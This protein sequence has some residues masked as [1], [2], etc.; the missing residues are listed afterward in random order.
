MS[1]GHHEELPFWRKYIFSTDHKMIGIQYSVTGLAFLFFGFC[2]MMLM[3]W[4]LAYPS[5]PI[6]LIGGLLGD[7]RA[8]GGIMLPDFYNELGAMHG[9]IMVFLGVVPL[10]VGGFGN[11]VLPLQLGA[12]DMA[13]PKI[14]M[15]SYW[16]LFLGG[17][18]MLGSFFLE[19]GAAQSGWTSYAPLSDIAPSGQTAW[20]IGMIFLITSSLLGSINFIA[21]TIQ[22]RAKGLSF[23]RMSFFCWAQFVT[24]FLL[25][26]AFPPLE[27]AGVLQLMDRVAET[28]FFLPYRL[29][30]SDHRNLQSKCHQLNGYSAGAERSRP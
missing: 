12:P 1:D 30:N 11:F 8:P 6:P 19:G 5:Q 4:Q 17:V 13:F 23:F 22:L 16:A 29:G 26:L 18:T 27:A 24:A 10:A 20:L 14:N 25:L 15:A 3:R 21:T 2:L 9:T 7:A 28:S